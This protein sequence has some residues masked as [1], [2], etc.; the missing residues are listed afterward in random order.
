MVTP[1]GTLNGKFSLYTP[2]LM[3]IT[4]PTEAIPTLAVIALEA[5]GEPTPANVIVS[6]SA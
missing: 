5:D 1:S 4:S 6:S 2:F 3:L